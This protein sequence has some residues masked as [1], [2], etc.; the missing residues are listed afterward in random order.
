MKKTALFVLFPLYLISAE[1]N[2]YNHGLNYYQ[3][4]QYKEAYPIVLE[5]AKKGNKEAQYLLGNMYQYGYG[6]KK[7]SDE[8]TLWYKKSSSTYA[9][10]VNRNTNES[11]SSYSSNKIEKQMSGSIQQGL[12]LIFSKLDTRLPEVK[13]E[14]QKLVDKD[15]GLLPYDINYLN[16]ISYSTSKYNKHYS[17]YVHDNLPSTYEKN[18][19]V[20]FQLS[21][22]KPLSYN[23]LGLNEYISVAYTQQV[24][25][26][27]YSDSAPFRETNYSPEIFMSIPSLYEVDQLN[28]LKRIQ[29]GYRHQ[30]NGQDGYRSRSW[31]R[32]FL[33]SFW[34]FENFFL[35]AQGWYRIP[36]TKKPEEFYTGVNPDVTG[37]DNPNIEE[38][39]GYGDIHLKYL[40][41]KNQFGFMLRNNLKLD[42]NRGAI[43]IDWSAPLP[44]S[45]NSYWYTKV[46]NGY[47]ESLIDYDKSI[48]KISV[49]FAFYRSMF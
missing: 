41:G 38:Y 46:F 35:K 17:Q 25:W 27:M 36:E 8:A 28:N 42:G 13:K 15:F 24:W 14:I 9:Y 20:E 11:N 3:N 10:I 32:L 16:P 18:M 30:S 34:Q 33:S 49:G 48:T 6:V 26:Q 7:D 29:F 39:L 31:N 1:M 5:E 40:Y 22:Q 21:L 47:G 23:L 2:D 44:H 19:E 4:Y 12:Q 37:D 43:Q 45:E